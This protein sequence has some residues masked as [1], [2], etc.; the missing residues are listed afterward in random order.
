M[1]L[2]KALVAAALGGAMGL[3][4]AASALTID[5][6]TFQEGAIFELGSVWE[7][8]RLSTC[9]SLGGNCNG[10]IDE[11]GEELVGVGYITSIRAADSSVLWSHGDNGRRL[12]IYFDSYIAESITPNFLNPVTEALETIIRFSGGSVKLYS[13]LN[14]DDFDPTLSQAD[15]IAAAT[16]GTLWLEL[17]GAPILNTTEFTPRFVSLV[18]VAS[19]INPADPLKSGLVSGD[20]RLDVVLREDTQA[21]DY[22]NTNQFGC[23]SVTT[24]GFCPYESD[25]SFT[26]VGNLQ[27]GDPGS[28]WVFSGGLMVRDFAIPEPGTLALLGAGL[29]GLGMRRRKVA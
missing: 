22:L 12:T 5:G 16:A 8:E 26:S 3:P 6:I 20:G 10:F 2:R 23:T 19:G 4:G 15:G 9:A 1:N 13:E 29:M 14:T 17:A 7:A 11:V 27:P 28:E 25:K 24:G 21:D 18:S